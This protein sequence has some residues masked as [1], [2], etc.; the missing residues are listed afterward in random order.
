MKIKQFVGVTYDGGGERVMNAIAKIFKS[1]IYV[2]CKLG[3]G[4]RFKRF[5][6]ITTPNEKNIIFNL[7]NW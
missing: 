6:E 5:K 2:A 3:K 4:K 1:K 7:T